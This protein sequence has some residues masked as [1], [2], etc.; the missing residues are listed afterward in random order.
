[1]A[2]QAIGRDGVDGD[3]R[4]E[5]VVRTFAF[6]WHTAGMRYVRLRIE[7]AKRLPDWHPSAGGTS[8][9]FVDEIVVR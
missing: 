8:W 1:V 7:N 2:W 3:Q 6:R 5:P 4:N 9:F